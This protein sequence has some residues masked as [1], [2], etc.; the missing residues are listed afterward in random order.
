MREA[1]HVINITRILN[2]HDIDAQPVSTGTT[3]FLYFSD[4]TQV[5]AA[6]E[7]LSTYDEFE[8]L[9]PEA[10]PA[11]ARLGNGGRL[12]DL[13]VS[14]RPPYFIEDLDS[15]P[16]WLQWLG[17]WG[18]DVM[19]AG[20]SLKATHGYPPDVGG[21]HGILYAWGSG[22]ARG[23]EVDRVRNIDVHPTVTRLLGIEPGRPIDG[24]VEPEL[25]AP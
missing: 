22:I 2:R 7:R 15:W 17:T 16:S 14:A 23:T 5:D 9:R 8:V 18:P 10:L 25:L 4:P 20:M 11:Y 6:A 12:G 3:S 1:T 13:I 19:W 24:A 21:M